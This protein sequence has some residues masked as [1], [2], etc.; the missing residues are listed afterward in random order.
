MIGRDWDRQPFGEITDTAIARKL[1]VSEVAVGKQRRKRGIAVYRSERMKGGC[2]VP[3]QHAGID[4]DN[5]PLGLVP[6]KTLARQLG[7]DPSSVRSARL[8]RE[9]K[10]EKANE[11]KAKDLVNTTDEVPCVEVVVRV[12]PLKHAHKCP[13]CFEA[14][15]CEQDC[16]VDEDRCTSDGVPLG[17]YRTCGPC[18]FE[19]E[20][21]TETSG[22]LV[23]VSSQFAGLG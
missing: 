15:D 13:M 6:D 20:N 19:L 3:G 18:A 5:Q 17:V 16:K 7:V 14:F 1:G 22:C 8:H 23:Q 10:R 4:W 21:N 12:G 9:R 2:R 11:N